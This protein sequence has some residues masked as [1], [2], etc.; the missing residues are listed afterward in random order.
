MIEREHFDRRDFL[1]RSAAAGIV[2]SGVIGVGVS[3]GE[4]A[5]AESFGSITTAG[6]SA[7]PTVIVDA[8]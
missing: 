2:I 6:G 5:W 7:G 3:T 1:R 4:A 8:L